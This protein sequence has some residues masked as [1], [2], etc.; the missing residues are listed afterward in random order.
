MRMAWIGLLC[1]LATGVAWGAKEPAAQQQIEASLDVS[2]TLAVDDKGI[3]TS[4]TIDHPE[5]L[6]PGVVGLIGKTI[7]TLHFKPV[8]RDGQPHAVEANMYLVL[9]ANHVDAQNVSIRIRSARFTESEPPATDWV[10]VDKRVEMR[11]PSE[12]VW[13]W[14][15][16]T[17]YVAVRID[18]NGRVI[19]ARAQQVNLR[20]VGSDKT[21]RRWREVL[22]KPALAT[23]RKY[24]FKIPTTGPHT[25]DSEFSGML[26]VI[27]NLDGQAPPK[28]GQWNSYV[29][30][31]R[32]S[33][34]WLDD[35]E[36][37][38]ASEAIPAGTFAQA[39]TAL[40]L[41]TPLG[42]G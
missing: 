17:V 18:R 37:A 31:P 39:G 25:D 24:T 4:H 12:A 2:G 41:L 38:S 3:V 9:V 5:K 34:A 10:T 15:G 23:I 19:D 21:M 1:L 8:L 33:I 40:K 27:F 29:P 14:F 20:K 13:E 36:D 42:D 35:K 32:E 22:S 26:P 7:P 16:G 11:F 30:G 6:S 28:Y